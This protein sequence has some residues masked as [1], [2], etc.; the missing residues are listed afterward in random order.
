MY[1]MGFPS[2]CCKY[3]LLQFVNKEAALPIAEQI[4]VRL[5]EI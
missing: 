2:I 4:I 3:I 1:D 5:E